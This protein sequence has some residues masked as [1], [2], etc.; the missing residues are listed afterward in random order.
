[1]RFRWFGCHEYTTYRLTGTDPRPLSYPGEFGMGISELRT[2]LDKNVYKPYDFTNAVKDPY[3]AQRYLKAGYVIIIRDDHSGIEDESGRIDHF[4]QVQ[5]H[6][7]EKRDVNALPPLGENS[8]SPTPVTTFK[9]TV[10]MGVGS[11]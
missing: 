1:M 2:W 10:P 7:G 9:P 11:F 4:I 5:G 6:A 8:G 3:K